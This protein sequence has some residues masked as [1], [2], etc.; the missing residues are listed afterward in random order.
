MAIEMKKAKV[1][2]N[3]PVY[4]GMSILDISKTLMYEFWYDYIK[5]KYQD[6]GKLCYVDSDRFV[7]YIKTEDFH[8][9]IA[10]DVEK[11]SE[12]F[13]YN[14][15]DKRPLSICKNKKKIGLFTNELGG[16]IIKNL[17]DLEQNMGIRNG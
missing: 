4:L 6:K 9:D 11:C 1:K 13:N 7:I 8:K 3:K 10:N 5:P 14:E 12:T 15:D 2:M 16:K 17:L